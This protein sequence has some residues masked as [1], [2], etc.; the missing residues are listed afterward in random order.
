MQRWLWFQ[1]RDLGKV[2]RSMRSPW[3]GHAKAASTRRVQRKE[4]N[5]L[6]AAISAGVL[7]K[8]CGF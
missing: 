5:A 4:E 8:V 6:A 3:K 2:M 7:L 1:E